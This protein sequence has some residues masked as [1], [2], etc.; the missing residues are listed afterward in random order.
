MLG[1]RGPKYPI[2]ITLEIL[3]K[4]AVGGKS[5]VSFRSLSAP[6]H[7]FSKAFER[8]VIRLSSFICAT[9]LMLLVTKFFAEALVIRNDKTLYYVLL[10]RNR[11]G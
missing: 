10:Y 5:L 4:E 8:K 9:R 11:V 6:V 7:T 1:Q 3:R 2:Y